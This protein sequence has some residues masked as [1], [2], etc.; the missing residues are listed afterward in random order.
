M[1]DEDWK[2]PEVPE[3]VQHLFSSNNWT[4]EDPSPACFCSC[5]GRKK[6][7][8]ECPAGA[9][10]LP[11]PE[12]RGRETQIIIMADV[13]VMRSGTKSLFTFQIM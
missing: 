9:G 5:E 10:G 13:C 12:V 11:P 6:M 2:T 1:G 4:M 7:L 3:S 8:P